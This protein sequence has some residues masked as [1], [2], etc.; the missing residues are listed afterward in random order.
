MENID[1]KLYHPHWKNIIKSYFKAN[2]FVKHQLDSYNDFIEFGIQKVLD[3][4]GLIEIKTGPE[5]RGGE[6]TYIIKFGKITI[7]KPVIREQDGT[8][9]ILYPH[10]ARIRNFTYHSSLYCDITVKTIKDNETIEKTCK[11]QL[12]YIPIMVKSK[13]CLLYGKTEKELKDMGECIYDEGGYFIVNGNEKAIIAQERMPH[14]IVYC[15]YKKPPSKIIWQTE[16]RSNF[17]YHIKTTSTFYIRAFSKGIRSNYNNS[18]FTDIDGLRGQITY[19][20]Q[21]IPIIFIFYA[22][23][24][25]SVN[26][27]LDII[28]NSRIPLDTD[29]YDEYFKNMVKFLR[30]S[31]DEANEIIADEYPKCSK[32]ELQNF[33]LDYIGKRGSASYSTKE[34]RIAYSIQILNKELLPHLYTNYED[35]FCTKLNLVKTK[36]H[37]IGYIINKIY[38]CYTGALKENDRD[39]LANKRV[40]LSGNLLTSLFKNI[41]KRLYKEAKSN[42]TKSIE[43]N[44]NFDLMNNIKSKSITNDIKYALSTGNWGRQVGGTPP[45]SGVA[46]QLNRL[47]FSSSLSHLRRLNTPLNR[48]G[49]QAKPRQ[50]HGTHYSYLCPAE[51]PE[52]AACGLLKNFAITCHVSIGSETTFT[53]LNKFFKEYLPEYVIETRDMESDVFLYKIFLD[54]A[55]NIS[56]D[57]KTIKYIVSKLKNL[58]RKLVIHYDTAISLDNDSK[59]L[60]VFTGAGRCCRPLIIIE[61]M[62]KITSEDKPWTE[63]LSEGIIEYIDVSEEEELMIAM[64]LEN[65]KEFPDKYTHLEIHPSVM[66]GICASIIPFPDHNQCLEYHTPVLMADGTTKMI[67]DIKIGESVITF[68]PDTLERSYSKVEYHMVKETDKKMHKITTLSNRE[69]IATFDHRFFTNKGF[70]KVEDFDKT[71]KLAIELGSI[72]RNS[73]DSKIKILEKEKFIEVCNKYKI[74]NF[75]LNKY[76]E[77]CKIWFEQ[78]DTSKIAILAG[79][80]G[81]LLADGCLYVSNG[82]NN[83]A[84]FCHSSEESATELINDME[85]IGFER[86]P[87]KKGTRTDIF[88]KNTETPREITQT[89]YDSYYYG[90]FPILL[91]SLGVITGKKTTKDS[92]IP[93]FIQNGDTEIQRSF[94]S[95]LFGGD[96]SKVRYT[97]LRNGT[98]EQVEMNVFSQSKDK[99]HLK[100][101]ETF[102]ENIRKMLNKFDI[103]T[104]ST[105]ISDGYFGKMKVDINFCKSADNIIKFYEEIGFKYD[106][107]KNQESGIIVEYLKYKKTIY[108]KK[109]E[110]INEIRKDIDNKLTQSQLIEKYDKTNNEIMHIKNRYRSGDSVFKIR[111]K[112]GDDILRIK[113]FID[114]CEVINNTLFVPIKFIDDYNECNIIADITVESK[115]HNFMA[116]NFLVHN[117]PRNIYQ[118]LRSTE[119]ILCSDGTTKMIKDIKLGDE[120]ITFDPT[121]TFLKRSTSKVV[122]HF[123]RPTDKKMV[124]ITTVFDKLVNRIRKIDVTEDHLFFTTKGWVQAG[125]L[126]REHILNID[127][128]GE[129]VKL[130]IKSVEQLDNKDILISDVSVESENHTFIGGDGFMVHNSAMGKQAMGKM[131]EN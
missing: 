19:I 79:I 22:L 61:N 105:R 69:I 110:E 4:L 42:L 57:E 119:H 85:Y 126:T 7:K 101:M 41:F 46:Q 1:N 52:G 73:V 16:I 129:N 27:I 14:N 64:N 72:K 9:N 95:G 97:L 25:V 81:Y 130:R 28:T 90:Y 44:N 100:S 53:F 131:Q 39:H 112:P 75:T 78:V 12:G 113:D 80:V 21:D 54:G 48:E 24:I 18:T 49:K 13:F 67:K 86:R 71:T 118:C 109:I 106:N 17:E 37:F 47:T 87:V 2:G 36:T 58:R 83:K 98:G 128:K 5:S 92:T 93:N 10:E 65:I 45:K 123:V 127:Y 38:L 55:W 74:K 94:L 31:F 120:V 76:I 104:I 102:M 11:E 107:L 43:A 96:G 70:I 63:F 66:L 124:T 40:E 116:N 15:F 103:Q 99:E 125:K 121:S 108:D 30:C 60:H 33:C 68:D 35:I 8:S 115:N 29:E 3:E 50:L 122:D 32:D 34:E 89:T 82:S 114:L 91:E 77:K 59:E 111:L 62:D 51:T 117:S 56:V 84:L 6:A 88:G 23:G 20:K 26:D